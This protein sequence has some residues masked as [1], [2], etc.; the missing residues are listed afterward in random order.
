MEGIGS[1]HAVGMAIR[2]KLHQ[3]Y[4]K[5]SRKL[6]IAA[7]QLF[8]KTAHRGGAKFYYSGF[9]AGRYSTEGTSGM[10]MTGMLTEAFR[11]QRLTESK[12]LIQVLL[13]IA[14]LLKHYRRL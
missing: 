6:P 11:V 12:K 10:D 7:D 5:Y 1:S 14:R 4:G 3:R 8:I 2:L 13:F 9:I